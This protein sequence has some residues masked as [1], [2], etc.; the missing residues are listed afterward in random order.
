MREAVRRPPRRGESGVPNQNARFL[1]PSYI[2]PWRTV[3]AM[4]GGVEQCLE[5]TVLLIFPIS[6]SVK[7]SRRK[8]VCSRV[9][10]QTYLGTL[11]GSLS[12]LEPICC[13]KMVTSQKTLKNKQLVFIIF[14]SQ[15]R[16]NNYKQQYKI[17]MISL[18]ISDRDFI[19]FGMPLATKSE[20]KNHPKQV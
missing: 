12:D 2:L 8:L 7:I 14:A 1:T 19:R 15:E 11:V 5:S 17:N 4:S 3:L 20:T 16:P 13:S 10:F 6:K 18:L 9:P